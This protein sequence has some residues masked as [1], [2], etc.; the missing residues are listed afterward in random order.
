AIDK[1]Q[2]SIQLYQSI[3]GTAQETEFYR[4]IIISLLLLSLAILGFAAARGLF[5]FFMR[6]TLIVTSRCIEYD[7]KNEIYSHYQKLSQSFYKLHSTG[8]LINRISEDVSRVRM[9]LGPGIM[10]TVNLIVL[11]I[12]VITIML[13]VNPLLSFFVLLPLPLLLIGIYYV[14]NLINKRSDQI[15][16]KLSD[17]TVFAHELFTGIRVIRA[18][19]MENLLSERFSGEVCEYRKKSLRL[20]EV[21]SVFHPLVLF[22]ISIS[23]L[24][25]IIIGGFLSLEGKVSPGNIAEFVFYVNLLTWPVASVGWVTSLIQRAAASQKR[26]NDFLSVGNDVP[27]G[28]VDVPAFSDSIRFERVTFTYP[29]SGIRALDEITLRIEKGKKTGII[30]H[31]GSGKTTFAQLILRVFDPGS[32][33]IFIDGRE[34]R[35]IHATSIR[36]L[37]AYVP[38]DI[39][40]FSDTIA[41]NILFGSTLKSNNP[42]RIGDRCT[43][44]NAAKGAGIA[45]EINSFPEKYNTLIGERGITLSGGQKQRIAIAR[46]LLREPDILLL[47]DC[48]SAVDPATEIE[49]KNYFNKYLIDRTIIFITHRVSSVMDCDEIFVLDHGRISEHGTH[50]TLLTLNGI[51]SRLYTLQLAEETN[52]N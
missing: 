12:I 31:T 47:D 10:Y 21:N 13:S 30:G 18:F 44:E 25:T 28:A 33:K 17:L 7:L 5:L 14:S 50:E 26:I 8:D 36:N 29:D 45:S 40:L 19:G 4:E 49:V 38:Q 16:E 39:F 24:V 6:Q 27:S 22:L 43:I 9:Y 15:Q 46:A 1:V 35:D 23:T 2:S 3:R 32:G 34:I 20:L 48:L 42:S 41:N 11:F 37:I 51:Y 52:K